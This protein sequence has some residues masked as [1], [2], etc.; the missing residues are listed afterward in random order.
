MDFKKLS[1]EAVVSYA[2]EH[3]GVGFE[4]LIDRYQNQLF[5]YT[6]RLIRD[7]DL[8]EDAVQDTFISAYQN[9][10][11]F[12]TSRKF[13]SWI[14]RIAHNKAINEIRRHKKQISLEDAPEI[15]SKENVKEIEGQLGKK[16]AR[17]ILEANINKLN[18]KYRGIIIL[19]YLEEKSYDEISDILKIPTSTVGVRIRRG[20]EKLRQSININLEDYL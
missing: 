9:I 16:Q 11:S 7:K 18:I 8:A 20:L 15:E 10:Q 14:Y 5:G 3:S 13:S 1:D 17:E 19:R 4:E 12:D 2:Q 6:I